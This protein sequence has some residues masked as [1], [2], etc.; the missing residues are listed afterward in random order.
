MWTSLPTAVLGIKTLRPRLSIELK[1][2]II[3][4][5]PDLI[6]D[7]EAG[8]EDCESRLSKLGDARQSV[9]EQRHYL[10][11][12]SQIFSSL[13]KAAIDGTYTDY[14]FEDAMTPDTYAKRLRP[15]I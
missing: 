10:V 6:K 9:H 2:Q 3:A 14:F 15:V 11:R 13:G 8:I 12:I 4:V 5:L 1:N 7:V